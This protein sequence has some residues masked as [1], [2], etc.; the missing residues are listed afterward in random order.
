MISMRLIR[1]LKGSGK[2]ILCGVLMQWVSLIMQI[3]IVFNITDRIR[4]ITINRLSKKE[5][6]I[7]A[8]FIIG[9]ILVRAL[10]DYAYTTQNF[11]AGANVKRYCEI[12]FTKK[13]SVSALHTKNR[14]TH[15]K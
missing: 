3:S 4:M 14:F 1:L 12:S 15:L 5:I 8:L 9:Y 11:Y 6:I 7:D 2:H 10:C 13:Y